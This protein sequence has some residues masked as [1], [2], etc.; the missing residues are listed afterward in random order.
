MT[1]VLPEAQRDGM[2]KQ[3]PLARLGDVQE[4]ADAVAFLVSDSAAYITGET[5]HVN[6]GMLMD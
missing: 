5:M 4:I 6:G 1:R 2:L 3:V